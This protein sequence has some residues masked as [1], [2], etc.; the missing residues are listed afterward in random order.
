MS[1]INLFLFILQIIIC[2]LL[3][4]S[5]L[6]QS[7][8]ED[9][10]NGIGAGATQSNMLSHKTNSIEPITKITIVLG[11]ILM[12]NSFLLASISTHQ[13]KKDNNKVKDYIE[14]IQ[15]PKNK[16]EK[17]INIKE[18]NNNKLEQ[19]EDTNNFNK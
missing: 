1:F 12:L 2:L 16:V 10:L 15:K 9:S 19:K 8:D 4:I 11:I 18:N 6:L 5:V 13:Y 3:I 14:S 17:K 7:S